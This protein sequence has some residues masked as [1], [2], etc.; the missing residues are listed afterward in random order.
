MTIS[1]RISLDDLRNLPVGEIAA[2]P[3]DQL[4][5]LQDE[6]AERLRAA[7][8]LGDWLDG[9]I[10]LRYGDQAQEA[11][12]AEGK[13]TGTIRLQD[14]PVTVISDLPKRIDWD[15][16]QLARI[17]ENIASAGE[18]PSEFIDTTLKMSERKFGALPESWRKGF[19]PARTVRT[20][21]PK[22]R[23]VLDGEMR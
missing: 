22:F 2:L 1:N 13:D 17:A 18:D 20:G 11:R 6:A 23:L 15:Q 12:R 4:M 21:K 19:E 8:S 9:A 16:T 7:K 14:G 10:A 3:G 5:L